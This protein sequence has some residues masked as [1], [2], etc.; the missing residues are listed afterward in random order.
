MVE[1]AISGALAAAWMAL[2]A[3]NSG[4]APVSA[5]PPAHSET[6]EVAAKPRSC[7]LPQGQYARF[8]AAVSGRL[9]AVPKLEQLEAV[10]FD[11]LEVVARHYAERKYDELEACCANI[12]SDPLAFEYCSAAS[13]VAN[14]AGDAAKLADA[15]P[16]TQARIDA[17][18]ELDLMLGSDSA[19]KLPSEPVRR[20]YTRLWQL[21]EAGDLRVLD[22]FMTMG[23]KSHGVHAEG[24]EMALCRV[25]K[26][27]PA[28]FASGVL[29][30]KHPR[31]V[32]ELRQDC[33]E[34]LE[35]LKS[36]ESKP[37]R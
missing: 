18:N 29:P 9:D 21:A 36:L 3:C 22:N 16:Q 7:S 19:R 17:S 34:V 12:R 13:A 28:P 11:V 31:V 23:E 5:T 4:P 2:G 24:A 25:R 37:S 15:M 26:V 20:Y 10:Y 8:S 35:Y 1:R 33:A 14:H 6:R 32:A 27:L 30:S